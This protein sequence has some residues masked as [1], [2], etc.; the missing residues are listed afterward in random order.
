LGS[1]ERCYGTWRQG[2][3]TLLAERSDVEGRISHAIAAQL[4]VKKEL[5]KLRVNGA[6]GGKGLSSSPTISM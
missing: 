2:S 1:E 5:L 4:T 3:V 6:P